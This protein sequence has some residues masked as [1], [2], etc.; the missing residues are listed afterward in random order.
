MAE[1]AQKKKRITMRRCE[2]VCDVDKINVDIQQVCAKY[3]TIKQ[4]A[5]INHDK[6]DTRPHYHIMLFFDY[7]VDIEEIARWFDIAPN[8]ICR[9]KGS[10]TD[11]LSYLIHRNESHL[12]KYQYNPDEVHAN[13][14]WL[15]EIEAARV[16]GDFTSY[17]YA[18]QIKFIESIKDTKRRAQASSLLERLW[19]QHCK[20]LSLTSHRDLQV[21]FI[22]GAAGTGKTYYAQK[23]CKAAGRDYFV[24]GASNDIF[25]GYAGQAAVILDDLR[26]ENFRRLEELLKILDNNTGSTVRSRYFNVTLCCDLIIIT[27]VVPLR[28]WYCEYKEC[29]FDNLQ[30]LYRRISNYLIITKEEIRIY[31][32]LDSCGRPIGT[33]T[34][35]Q[36]EVPLL[37]KEAKKMISVS[38]VFGTMCSPVSTPF[39]DMDSDEL[40]Y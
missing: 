34:I 16:I 6:D 36:N 21:V 5:Y 11:A 10:R 4:W 18:R 13:F 15:T 14:D 35:F 2:I 20:F 25:D 22:E 9:I 40:P 17:S 7:P 3:S 23:F 19:R 29:K 31:S 33:A 32:E 37:K 28:E 8:F 24:S 27:S 39:D 26:D 38:D 1:L 30:Q 12:W